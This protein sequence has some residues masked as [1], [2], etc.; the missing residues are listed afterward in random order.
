MNIQGDLR[1]LFGSIR[2]LGFA[3]FEGLG[4]GGLGFQVQAL[5]FPLA[6]S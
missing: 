6:A 4:S 1:G 5:G 2:G 3:G